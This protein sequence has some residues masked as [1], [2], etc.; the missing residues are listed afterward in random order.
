MA[1]NRHRVP[2]G[3]SREVFSVQTRAR[4]PFAD[5][6]IIGLHEP[7][8]SLVLI[9]QGAEFRDEAGLPF[10]HKDLYLSGFI[11]DLEILDP[12]KRLALPLILH[13]DP[14]GQFD[15]RPH[16]RP[17]LIQFSA[18]RIRPR[19][20]KSQ[21]ILKFLVEPHGLLTSRIILTSNMI[22]ASLVFHELFHGLSAGPGGTVPSRPYLLI[23]TSLF[24]RR[25]HL[26]VK[27]AALVRR[28]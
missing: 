25:D 12:P 3:R 6:L 11:V 28:R 2:P 14:E 5:Q 24:D 23:P 1:A 27:R 15:V 22:R 7:V 13:Q 4:H 16:A 26:S 19:G 18:E 9:E 20:L 8:S 17:G 10:R 21:K